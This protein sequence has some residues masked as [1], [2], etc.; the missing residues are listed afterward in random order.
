MVL[1]TEEKV[2]DI[3]KTFREKEIPCDAI[4][5]DID[6]MDGY[7]VFTFDEEKFPNPEKM[8]NQLKDWGIN[9]VAIMDP[10]IKRD[11]DFHIYRDCIEKNTIAKTLKETQPNHGCGLGYAY[12]QILPGRRFENGGVIYISFTSI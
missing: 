6:Y 8:V 2:L 4:H 7:R 12:F 11:E 3:A 9:T 10:G 1:R 5:L